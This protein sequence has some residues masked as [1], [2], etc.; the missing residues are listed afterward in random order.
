MISMDDNKNLSQILQE[1]T[2]HFEWFFP[3]ILISAT[4]FFDIS[5]LQ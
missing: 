4:A 5:L 1:L 3:I 2:M